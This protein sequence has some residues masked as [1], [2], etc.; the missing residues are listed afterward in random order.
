[1]SKKA[2]WVK[3]NQKHLPISQ[4]AAEVIRRRLAR[5]RKMM[6]LAADDWRGNPE[7]VH[8][9]RVAT[10]RASAA[11]RTF[12][13]LIPSR[14][15]AKLKKLL[16]KPRR[17]AGEARDLDVLLARL[18]DESEMHGRRVLDDVLRR[19]SR[20][21]EQS[22]SRIKKA[23]ARLRHERFKQKCS[24]LVERVRW[25]LPTAEPT[26]EVAARTLL[27]GPVDNFFTAAEADLST[28]GNLHALRIAGKR[29]R[30]TMELLATAL[31][32]LVRDDLY[33]QIRALQERLG[34]LNDHAVAVSRFRQLSKTVE[35][36][37]SQ[38]EL[39]VLADDESAAPVRERSAFLDDWN[40]RQWQALQEQLRQFTKM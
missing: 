28:T 23:V 39:E 19:L 24:A 7:H 16:R 12:E 27:R 2:K 14:R 36:R 13:S 3:S 6:P 21:R 35:Q 25:R 38:Y 11:L 5:V 18:R 29:L 1:M 4:V 20:K 34:R 10:R 8:Q 9:L 30:Y 17:A 15:A 37:V 33:V 32:D 40:C 22:Q 26:Y 31:D